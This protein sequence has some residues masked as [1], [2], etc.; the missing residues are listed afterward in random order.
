MKKFLL[1]TFYSAAVC[2][3]AVLVHS[4]YEKEA[5]DNNLL[6]ANVE[7][8]TNGDDSSSNY[9]ICYHKSKV[10]LGYTYYD[11][12]SCTKVYDEQGKGSASKC[13]K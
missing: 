4:L 7:A 12:G 13:F 1:G 6:L 3:C 11:C 9:S 2:G 10:K 8:L 5:V